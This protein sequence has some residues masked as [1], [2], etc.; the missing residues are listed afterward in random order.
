MFQWQEETLVALFFNEKGRYVVVELPARQTESITSRRSLCDIEQAEAFVADHYPGAVVVSKPD[1]EEEAATRKARLRHPEEGEQ[2]ARDDPFAVT[3]LAEREAQEHPYLF[4]CT[5]P[6]DRIAILRVYGAQ[7][8]EQARTAVQTCWQ[9]CQ[10]TVAPGDESH[11]QTQ[12]FTL[13]FTPHTHAGRF[14][15]GPRTREEGASRWR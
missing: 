7:S 1:L 14:G 2:P 11:G 10:Y 3:V 6:G 13:I 12:P 15:K 5:F 4:T 9:K 8:Q